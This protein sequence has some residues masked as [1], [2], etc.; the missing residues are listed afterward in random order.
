MRKKGFLGL[1]ILMTLVFAFILAGPLEAAP[2]WDKVKKGIRHRVDRI[3]QDIEDLQ[4]DVGT[5][6]DDLN[7]E[8]QDREDGDEALQVQIDVLDGDIGGL[9]VPIAFATVAANGTKSS[10][11]S[12]VDVS[13]SA[14]DYLVTFNDG[15]VYDSA[16]Y[17]TNV[18]LMGIGT[19]AVTVVTDDDGLESLVIQ[20]L[21]AN[22]DLVESAFQFVVYKVPE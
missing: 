13:G 3:E 10:G 14:G 8:I 22:S 12:N 15:E 18:T 11:T 2:D 20:T 19:G 5:L 21:D 4:G 17:T 6:R 7:T 9:Y 16:N 1:A